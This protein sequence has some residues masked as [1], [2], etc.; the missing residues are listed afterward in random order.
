MSAFSKAWLFFAIALISTSACQAPAILFLRAHEPVPASAMATMAL[1]SVA[2][3]LVALCLWF[4]ERRSLHKQPPEP[5]TWSPPRWLLWT[6][7]LS[8]NPLAHL[9]G[10]G[11]LSLLGRNTAQHVVYLPLTPEQ[12]A[13]AIIAPLGEEFGFRGYALP[14]LQARWSPLAASL[15]IGVVWAVWH[16]PTLLVPAARGTSS[17][18]LW[19]YLLSFVAGSVVYTWF[20]NAGRGS[21]VAPLLAH[22]GIHADNVF[23]ASMLGDGV[24]PLAATALCMTGMAVALVATGQLRSATAV[25]YTPRAESSQARIVPTTTSSVAELDSGS[26]ERGTT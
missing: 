16:I 5:G 10:S 25:L 23:R 18:E 13:I 6:C 4:L 19:L 1:G 22:F 15:C 2:P 8:F 21:M 3:S 26:F 14:R 12:L 9:L 24:G 7:A 11:L 20:Y 17:L